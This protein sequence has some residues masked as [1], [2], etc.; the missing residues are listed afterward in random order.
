M[1]EWDGPEQPEL[2]AKLR[3]MLEASATIDQPSAE[4]RRR[5]HARLAAAIGVAPVMAKRG[6]SAADG[7]K[8]LRLAHAPRPRL[9]SGSDSLLVI[10]LLSDEDDCSVRSTEALQPTPA[11]PEDSP[12]RKQ[13]ISLRCFLNPQLEYDVTDRYLKGLRAL[14]PGREDQVMFTA[15]VGVP[16]D[17][18]DRSAIANHAD[19]VPRSVTATHP[20]AAQCGERSANGACTSPAHD[21]DMHSAPVCGCDGVTYLNHCHASAAGMALRYDADGCDAFPD[22]AG[23]Q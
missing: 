9:T 20:V 23:M 17:L 7:G 13:D 2:R 21:C 16:A 12:Y 22:D 10:A 1:Q 4:D 3:A 18:V 15:I 19:R 6:Q 5:V 14:R 8:T 11:L